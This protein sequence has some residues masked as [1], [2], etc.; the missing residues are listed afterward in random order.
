[1]VE[2]F[3]NLRT[4][5]ACGVLISEDPITNFTALDFPPMDFPC[6][7]SDMYVA[8]D[9]KFEK[10]NILSQRSLGAIKDCEQ[11][12]EQ[13]RGEKVD[14]SDP[15]KFFTDL[16]ISQQLKSSRTAGCFYIESPP[17]RQL[18]TKL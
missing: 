17:M 9:I 11:I 3:P 14:I 15:Y 8:E 10:F 2:D 6:A 4:P 7:Q 12:I 16:I 5:H 1:M 18:I 13:D